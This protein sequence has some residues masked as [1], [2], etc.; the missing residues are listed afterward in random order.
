M[1]DLDIDGL[2][3]FLPPEYVDFVD[4]GPGTRVKVIGRTSIGPGWNAEERR[5]DPEQ[6][7]VIMNA[8]GMHPLPASKMR[9][10]I[11]EEEIEGFE[12]EA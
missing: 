3:V 8:F 6:K 5:V 9:L 12:V 11:E 4:Y 1:L 7:R 2:T 10:T